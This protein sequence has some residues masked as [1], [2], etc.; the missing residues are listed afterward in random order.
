MY[1]QSETHS[2]FAT[3]RHFGRYQQLSDAVYGVYTNV[4]TQVQKPY[5]LRVIQTLISRRSAGSD[6]SVGLRA[7]INDG[8]RRISRR[9]ESARELKFSR[10]P[11]PN[12]VARIVFF[13]ILPWSGCGISRPFLLRMLEGISS[14]LSREKD[15]TLFTFD[16]SLY[17]IPFRQRFQTFLV[18]HDLDMSS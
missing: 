8:L 4:F 1:F 15:A 17:A 16:I 14:F 3:L 2:F 6:S 9:F 7:R 12:P 13:S 18:W 10:F 11:R 5:R